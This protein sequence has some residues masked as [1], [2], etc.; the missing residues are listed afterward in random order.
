MDASTNHIYH[1]RFEKE[2]IPRMEDAVR[3]AL[4]LG[5]RIII[6]IKACDSRVGDFL[7]KLFDENPELYEKALVA[8]FFPQVH[9]NDQ[10]QFIT[11]NDYQWIIFKYCKL[12][13]KLS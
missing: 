5:L 4:K 12:T 1:D 13:I 8:S 6:D 2:R 10:S 3:E 11:W 9:S 7:G